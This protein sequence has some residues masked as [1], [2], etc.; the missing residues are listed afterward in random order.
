[1][2][3][4][5]LLMF[6][7]FLLKTKL[8]YGSSHAHIGPSVSTACTSRNYDGSK[9]R[10]Q[11]VNTYTVVHCTHAC[12]MNDRFLSNKAVQSYV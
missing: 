3:S 10:V 8:S 12:V 5:V 6:G 11:S 4:D 7:G 9:I 2:T 1:M